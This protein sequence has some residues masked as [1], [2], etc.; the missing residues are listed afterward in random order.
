MDGCERAG[1][2]SRGRE[3]AGVGRCAWEGRVGVGVG[4]GMQG[5]EQRTWLRALHVSI[6]K[7]LRMSLKCTQHD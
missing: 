7:C 1:W 4:A 5:K 6:Q 3:S 2:G